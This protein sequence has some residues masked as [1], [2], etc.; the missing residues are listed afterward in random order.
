MINDLKG[1]DISTGAL[2]SLT[3]D[4]NMSSIAVRFLLVFIAVDLSRVCTWGSVS[5]YSGKWRQSSQGVKCESST[6]NALYMRAAASGRTSSSVLQAT[7]AEPNMGEMKAFKKQAKGYQTSESGKYDY[8][9]GNNYVKK[10]SYGKKQ[11]R[12]IHPQVFKMFQRAQTLMKNGDNVVAQR[13]LMRCLE[14]NPTTHIVG[15]HWPS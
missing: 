14:L 3:L 10:P 7:T 4:K 1:S 9:K 5:I 13:L 6:Y 2:Y 15:W 8:S 11:T 12:F